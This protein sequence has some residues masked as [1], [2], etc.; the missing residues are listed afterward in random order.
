MPE[1][2]SYARTDPAFRVPGR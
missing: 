2:V 1:G